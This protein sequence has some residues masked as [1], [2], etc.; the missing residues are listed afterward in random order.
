MDYIKFDN[1]ENYRV[2]RCSHYNTYSKDFSLGDY[3][4]ALFDDNIYEGDLA[5]AN[6]RNGPQVVLVNAIVQ[7]EDV[8]VKICSEL[9]AKIDAT[10]FLN[11]QDAREE[12][13]KNIRDLE[14]LKKAMDEKIQKLKD[15]V[16]YENMANEFSNKDPELVEMA[17]KYKALFEKI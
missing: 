10:S 7:K 17:A 9:I 4:F 13:K 11:R 6:T 16:F 14:L 1:N 8:K 3:F 12:K 2:A 15:T 5:V